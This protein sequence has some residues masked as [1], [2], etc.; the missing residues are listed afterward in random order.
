VT[1]ARAALAAAA[2]AAAAYLPSLRNT[3]AL[4]D[5]AIV[6]R[7]PAAHSVGAALRAFDQS[8]WPPQ[9]G[10]GQWRPLVVLSFAVDWQLSRG[11]TA[12]LHA[13]NVVWHAAATGLFVLVIAPYVSATAALAG[14]VL[15]AVHPVH[16]EAVANLVGRAEL[17]AAFFLFLALLLAR[18]V[19]ARLETGRRTWT[20]EMGL[21]L[22]VAG[23]LLSKEHA[24]LAAALLL[25][26]D[27]GMRR[28]GGR[29][30]PWRDYAGVVVLTA[31]WFLLRVPI[32]AG[33]SFHTIA[34][35][36]FGLGTAGRLST[37]LPV[38]FVLVRLLAWPFDLFPD[39]G[40]QVVPRLEH[41]TAL[42]LAGLVVVVAAGVLAVISWRRHRGLSVGLWLVAV[43]WLPTSNILF[44]TGV[45]IAER[46]LYL[47]SAGAVLVG[48]CGFDWLWQGGRRLAAASLA[49]ALAIG[50][51]ART[52]T[53]IAVWR[54]NRDLV[55]WALAAHPEAYRE[56]LAAARALMRLHDVSAASREYQYAIELYGR[57]PYALAEAA[58]S[59]AAAGSSRLAHED[60]RRAAEMAGSDSLAWRL[61]A[62][63]RILV[64]S[65]DRNRAPRPPSPAGG[66]GSGRARR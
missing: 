36:F 24:A 55:L 45:V 10:A 13:D 38:V 21:L 43:A 30:L 35:T 1:P 47:A 4:D 41:V 20:A 12:W 31:V 64:D 2:V 33:R 25:L 22:S 60:L 11:S 58:G 49:A 40:P 37:M 48:S 14:G 54:N 51:A 63:V 44:P 32:D 59:A 7:N 8:Y 57:D 50:F 5:G 42:G 23:A 3:F 9:N 18:S 39:Y 34:P 46:T 56:H 26:D 19:R 6:Q 52:V 15:F 66:V 29:M 17:M 65:L 28:P 62:E 61:V 27:V 16:V 53:Q